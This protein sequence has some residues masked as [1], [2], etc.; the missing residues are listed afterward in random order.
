MREGQTLRQMKERSAPLSVAFSQAERDLVRR[1][2]AMEGER[3]SAFIRNAA[4]K[5]AEIV[6]PP[7]KKGRKN[8]A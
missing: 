6:A 1:A 7:Q 5:A 4:V 2:A 3:V 8:A